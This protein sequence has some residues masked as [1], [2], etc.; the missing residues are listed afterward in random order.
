MAG[1]FAA[2]VTAQESY[3]FLI[4]SRCLIRKFLQVQ[5]F[6]LEEVPNHAKYFRHTSA[7][8]LRHRPAQVFLH[9]AQQNECAKAFR[10]LWHK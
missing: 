5:W 9:N 7:K 2:R 4:W 10:F 3:D 8:H 1:V 6:H